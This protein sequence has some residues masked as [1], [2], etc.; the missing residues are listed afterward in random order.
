MTAPRTIRTMMT[1]LMNQCVIDVLRKVSEAD[2][3][4]LPW[5]TALTDARLARVIDTVLDRPGAPH[6]LDTLAALAA[7]SRSTFVRH[8]EDHTG[9]T[10][11]DYVR[12]VRLRSAAKLL[13]AHDDLSVDAVAGK[14]G[15]ASRSQFSRAFSER[16][17]QS[18]A[19]FR[20]QLS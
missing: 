16:F 11:M 2:A 1:A 4:S 20:R 14:V 3:E 6:T 19:D 7:M 17:G 12:D 15:Y 10:P 9:R 5:L 18:P 8:F 13:R